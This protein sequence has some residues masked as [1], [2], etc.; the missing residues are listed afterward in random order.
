MDSVK[1][2]LLDCIQCAESLTSDALV[3]TPLVQPVRICYPGPDRKVRSPNAFTFGG[4]T[5]ASATTPWVSWH[6]LF[7]YLNS[8]FAGPRL[9]PP[10]K[11]S[12]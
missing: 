11:T 8:S 12:V 3:Y 2:A 9:L 10:S 6:A 7:P 4:V 1:Q 5:V